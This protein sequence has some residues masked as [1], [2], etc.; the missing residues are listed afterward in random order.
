M[1]SDSQQVEPYAESSGDAL[2]PVWKRV[3]HLPCEVGVEL[4]IPDCRVGDLVQLKAGA[5]LDTSWKVGRDLPLYVNQ[6]V[7]AWV[8][9]EVISGH[10]AVRVTELADDPGEKHF[11]SNPQEISESTG[12]AM[13]AH[14]A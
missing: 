11:T 1:E 9:F 10:L 2:P 6:Q 4:G 13:G 8:E 7:V 3:L 5:V 12:M 14:A